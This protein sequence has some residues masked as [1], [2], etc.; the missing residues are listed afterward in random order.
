MTGTS[1]IAN[2]NTITGKATVGVVTA[3]VGSDTYSN[4]SGLT[5]S[6]TDL[7]DMTISD[8]A[9]VTEVSALEA[10][11]GGTITLAVGSSISDT[12]DNLIVDGAVHTIIFS[13]LAFLCLLK[14]FLRLHLS[15]SWFQD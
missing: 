1:S 15:C 11:T 12:I 3:N 8:A 7:I 2:V 13:N 14:V 4:L 6:A 9:G 5:S 10:K